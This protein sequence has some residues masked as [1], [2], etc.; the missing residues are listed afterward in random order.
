MNYGGGLTRA[1]GYFLALWCLEYAVRLWRDDDKKAFWPAT[2]LLA[3][4][5]SCHIERARFLV[6]AA[7]LVWLV[8]NHSPRGFLKF[9]AWLCIGIALCAPWW[10]T[11]LARFGLEP[12]QASFASGSIEPNVAAQLYTALNSELF[13]PIVTMLALLGFLVYRR[14]MPFVGL[15]FVAITALE[16]RSTRA[17]ITAP[18]ALGAALMI[19]KIRA[20]QIRFAVAGVLAC[21]LSFQ[22]TLTFA[23]SPLSQS[24]RAAMVWVR[25]NTAP[26]STFLVLPWS[27]NTG[28]FDDRA[29]EWFPSIARRASPLTVQGSEWL[30]P[31]G[32]FARLIERYIEVARARSWPSALQIAQRGNPRFDYVWLSSTD[33]LST[34]ENSAREK[35]L[36]ADPRWEIAFQ[37]VGATVFK[38]AD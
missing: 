13:P 7:F 5:V 21:W 10:A 24:Q 12:F 26:D 4:T 2:I 3:L 16:L 23:Q 17:F 11:C 30:S 34:K 29:L 20:S 6:V 28:W 22:S 36:R 18:I 37:N 9:G 1:P 32:T 15:W 33:D 38:R 35:Q 31:P 14:E 25:Q 8:F 27:G 19:G